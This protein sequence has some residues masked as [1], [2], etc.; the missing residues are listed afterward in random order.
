M[1]TF[2]K[3]IKHKKGGYDIAISSRVF[4]TKGK[5]NRV[6]IYFD[7]NKTFEIKEP[8][9]KKKGLYYLRLDKKT[10]SYLKELLKDKRYIVS[11]VF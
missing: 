8:V 11:E 1:I 7:N 4:Q 3:I 6:I 2:L 5:I 9:I 10:K